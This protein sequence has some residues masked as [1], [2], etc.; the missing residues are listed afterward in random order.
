MPVSVCGRRGSPVIA[1]GCP[2]DP[3][4]S[5]GASQALN[6][7]LVSPK[8]ISAV[9]SAIRPRG[10][11]RR[12]HS[13]DSSRKRRPPAQTRPHACRLPPPHSSR[14]SA[15]I[16][17][18]V[19]RH[20]AA[21]A[22][23]PHGAAAAAVAWRRGVCQWVN[24]CG[25]ALEGQLRFQHCDGMHRAPSQIAGAVLGMGSCVKLSGSVQL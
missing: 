2:Q 21:E 24:A 13:A 14:C 16:R 9:I 3:L 4:A 17:A 12:H 20:A 19:A 11:H 15:P 5:R 23:A 18:L 10:F 25:A 7:L 1:G 6:V 22:T 8:A